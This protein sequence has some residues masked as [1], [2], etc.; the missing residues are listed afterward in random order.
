[1]KLRVVCGCQNQGIK[2]L[3][4]VTNLL[5]IMNLGRGFRFL[6]QTTTRFPETNLDL[7][8]PRTLS[9]SSHV[10]FSFNDE[11]FKIKF[12]Q[13]LIAKPVTE[14][15][16][17]DDESLGFSEETHERFFSGLKTENPS[18]SSFYYWL[19]R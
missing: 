4:S 7:Y 19:Q 17:S 10:G 9:T 15:S 12:E 8:S 13:K 18:I 6:L 2:L 3:F 5:L 11:P 16:D 14:E 1:M